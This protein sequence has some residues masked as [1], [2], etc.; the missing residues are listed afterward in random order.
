M[1]RAATRLRS[2]PRLPRQRVE[3]GEPRVRLEVLGDVQG[4][5]EILLSRSPWDRQLT[6]PELR[7]CKDE[8]QAVAE[9]SKV[10]EVVFPCRQETPLG[11]WKI[12]SQTDC[13]GGSR[14]VRGLTKHV[15]IHPHSHLEHPDDN[16]K[17][18]SPLRDI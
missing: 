15:S 18:K 14:C 9:F 4:G 7:S 5:M 6:P 2:L 10:L 8:P 13:A 17:L 1:A 3:R 12:S 16:S 11:T